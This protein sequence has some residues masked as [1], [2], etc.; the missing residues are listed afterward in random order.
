VVF[1]KMLFVAFF[2]VASAWEITIPDTG[3]HPF[4]YVKIIIYNQIIFLIIYYN[5]NTNLNLNLNLNLKNA[6]NLILTYISNSRLTTTWKA[7]PSLH[8]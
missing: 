2:A 3:S 4:T 7:C 1:D 6:K 8:R 5:Y